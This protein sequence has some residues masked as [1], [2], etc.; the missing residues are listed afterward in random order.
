M[1]ARVE[2]DIYASEA[3]E[4]FHDEGL[5]QMSL[6]GS[7]SES[8]D[9]DVGDVGYSNAYGNNSDFSY[10][11][12]SDAGDVSMEETRPQGGASAAFLAALALRSSES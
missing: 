4:Q 9:G 3:S 8:G 6:L 7:E 1:A 10:F 2:F 5:Q 12:G 11:D